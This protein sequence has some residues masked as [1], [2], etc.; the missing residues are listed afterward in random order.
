MRTILHRFLSVMMWIWSKIYPYSMGQRL[1]SHFNVMY[2]LWIRNFIGE[3]GVHSSIIYPCQLQGK[4]QTNITIGDDTIIHGNCILGCWME[5]GNQ[6]FQPSIKIGNHCRIGEYNHITACQAIMI[7]D[8]LLTGRFVYIGD[9]SHGGLSIDEAN[10]PPAQ[11][12]LQSKG[13]I[14]IG[15]NVWIGDKS[16]I[17]AGVHIGD[18][19][20]VAANAVV[21]KDI[22]SNC[23]VAGVPAEIIKRL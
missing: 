12:D 6:H 2:T 3:V 13:E 1:K 20:I 9:N 21:T 18:N 14:I 10:T 8:G 16:T 23:L 5:Y 15:K 19:V 11:R 4:G 17:L 7:G 22:P